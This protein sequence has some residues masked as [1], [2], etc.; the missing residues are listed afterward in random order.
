MKAN[1]KRWIPK[2]DKAEPAP[3]YIH[4]NVNLSIHAND[5]MLSGPRHGS[6]GIPIAEVVTVSTPYTGADYDLH[7]KVRVYDSI[8]K[9][10]SHVENWYIK[11]VKV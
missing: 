3:D 5:V 6:L 11:I 4:N 1:I 8:W 2:D 10:R 7:M 9:E